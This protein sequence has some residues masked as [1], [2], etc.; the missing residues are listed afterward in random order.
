[1]SLTQHDLQSIK[2]I[3]QESVQESETRLESKLTDKIDESEKRL[4]GKL[5]KKIRNSEGRLEKRLKE[6]VMNE[7][8]TQL[9]SQ[10]SSHFR[11]QKIVLDTEFRKINTKF[12]DLNS[13]M[14]KGFVQEDKHLH[15]HDIQIATLTE[16]VDDIDERMPLHS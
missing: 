12:D 15:K 3:V 8:S 16:R 7:L 10:L 6:F 13:R 5:T 4:E 14:S 1:M 9:E 2:D 11:I